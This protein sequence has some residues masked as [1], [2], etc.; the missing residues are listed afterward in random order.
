[1]SVQFVHA[2]PKRSDIHEDLAAPIIRRNLR[3]FR[4]ERKLSLAEAALRIGCS[5]SYVDQIETGKRSPPPL[6]MLRKMLKA[7]GR[8]LE[9]ADMETP[10]PPP[11]MPEIQIMHKIVGDKADVAL[12]S[13]LVT[14]AQRE[15]ARLEKDILV[16]LR[17]RKAANRSRR[18]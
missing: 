5:L 7:Y 17:K 3:A 1:M 12:V 2:M 9:H 16:E 18:S 4:M 10:P 6:M 14:A 15:M 13:D 11:D 8:P